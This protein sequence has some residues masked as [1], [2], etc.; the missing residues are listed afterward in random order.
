MAR[1]FRPEV[2][3]APFDASKG[4]YSFVEDWN[5]GNEA[6]GHVVMRRAKFFGQKLRLNW[7]DEFT[8]SNA[9]F[10]KIEKGLDKFA[11][12]KVK[13]TSVWNKDRKHLECT[14][15]SGGCPTRYN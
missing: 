11:S 10:T 7:G 6:K 2:H 9:T 15:S 5:R 8:I 13:G 1:Y 14:L 4:F 12:D 3:Q